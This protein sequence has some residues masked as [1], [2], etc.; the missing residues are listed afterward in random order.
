M[1]SFSLHLHVCKNYKRSPIKIIITLTFVESFPYSLDDI[2]EISCVNP[3][4]CAV[5]SHVGLLLVRHIL[6]H[7]RFV[8]PLKSI[9]F[10]AVGMYTCPNA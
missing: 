4:K 5:L 10:Q 2:S 3:T 6:L 8:N 7:T 1:L 9:S